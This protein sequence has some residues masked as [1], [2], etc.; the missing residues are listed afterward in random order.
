MSA[1]LTRGLLQRLLGQWLATLLLAGAVPG[2]LAAAD[3]ADLG[4]SA[5]LGAMSGAD[6]YHHICQ[7][8]H[9]PAGQGAV[10]AGRY[11]KLVGDPALASW[12]FVALTVIAGR[13][14]MPAFGLPPTTAPELRGLDLSVRLSDAQI[15]GVVNFVRGTFGH[16]PGAVTASQVAELRHARAAAGK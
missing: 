5:R 16:L 6:I 12:Q 7:G 11:P 15:A 4:S 1:C 8:C 2:A 14:A 13:N 9:M 10:G 3:A